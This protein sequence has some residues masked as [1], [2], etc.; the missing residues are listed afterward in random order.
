LSHFFIENWIKSKQLFWREIGLCS[1]Y[2]CF[3]LVDYYSK[4]YVSRV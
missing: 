2:S 3:F 1:C 4:S